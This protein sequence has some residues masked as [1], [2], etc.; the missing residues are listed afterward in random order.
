MKRGRYNTKHLTRDRKKYDKMYYQKNLAR[1][2]A[3]HLLRY[4][5]LKGEKQNDSAER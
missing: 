3:Q 1:I 5:I 4:I 2:L